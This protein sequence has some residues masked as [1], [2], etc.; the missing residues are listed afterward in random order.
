MGA[1]SSGKVDILQISPESRED[2]VDEVAHEERVILRLDGQVH[3]FYCIPTH[4]EDMIVGNLRSRGLEVPWSRVK[5]GSAN[6]FELDSSGL[7]ARR[8]T[9]CESR[10]KLTK[11][12]VFDLAKALNRNSPLYER[13]G[14]AHVIGIR[15][16]D[17]EIFVEDISR[18]CAIDKAIGIAIKRGIDLTNSVLIGSCRQTG[19]TIR[20]AIFCQI[21]IVISIAAPTD[22]AISEASKYGIT[23]LGFASPQRFNI[24]SHPWRIQI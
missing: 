11:G 24:Y 13:T 2:K 12:E 10:K 17:R 19:S 23:L 18:H 20:K 9:V 16:D 6:E 8:P 21:P 4:L 15:Q 14:C 22:L 7:S 1:G 5:R 3:E